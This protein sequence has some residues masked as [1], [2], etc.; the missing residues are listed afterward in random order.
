[1]ENAF[2]QSRI[3]WCFLLDDMRIYRN[4]Q[5]WIA[6][7][8]GSKIVLAIVALKCSKGAAV[9]NFFLSAPVVS[10]ELLPRIRTVWNLKSYAMIAVTDHKISKKGKPIFVFSTVVKII[11]VDRNRVASPVPTT[12]L[13]H[14]SLR[15]RNSEEGG[16][17]KKFEV[18]NGLSQGCI[19]SW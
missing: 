8:K 10:S 1:M 12:E 19:L 14:V 15:Y 5:I 13:S 3:Q 7:P 18:K 11:L 16:I 2:H 4:M 17:L 6:L 9:A